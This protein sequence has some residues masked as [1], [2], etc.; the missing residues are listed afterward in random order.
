MKYEPKSKPKKN[1]FLNELKYLQFTIVAYGKNWYI[2]MYHAQSDL[3][4]NSQYQGRL[5][6]QKV[7]KLK[8]NM[9]DTRWLNFLYSTLWENVKVQ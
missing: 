7:L 5:K 3:V 1:F 8:T 6:T 2:E 4:W 9:A